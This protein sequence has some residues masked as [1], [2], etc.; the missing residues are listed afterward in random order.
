VETGVNH[1]NCPYRLRSEFVNAPAM[2]V[3]GVSADVYQFGLKHDPEKWTPVFRKDHAPT[4]KLN[5]DPI[6]FYRIMV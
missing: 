2:W 4:K 5:H 3:F 6:Q 1:K